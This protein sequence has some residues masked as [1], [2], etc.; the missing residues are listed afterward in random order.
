MMNTETFQYLVTLQPT[1]NFYFGGERHFSFSGEKNYLVKS[2]PFP[3][4]TTL[5]GMLRYEL[6]R[7]AGLL[8]GKAGLTPDQTKQQQDLIGAKGF[9]TDNS[10][11]Y[12]I[13]RQLSPVFLY[14]RNSGKGFLHRGN[15][16]QEG[17]A[18]YPI[19][20]STGKDALVLLKGYDAKKLLDEQLIHPPGNESLDM[21]DIYRFPVQTG[22]QKNNKQQE[23][24]ALY[25]QTYCRF[26]AKDVKG[27]PVQ[28]CF[29]F[30][31]TTSEPIALAQNS[32]VSMGGDQSAFVL[33]YEAGS[34][35]LFTEPASPEGADLLQV[36]LLS[37]AFCEKDIGALSDAAIA[38]STGFRFIETTA[39]TKNYYQVTYRK[40]KTESEDMLR[41]IKYNLYKAGA[42]FWLSAA[43]L[44]NFREALAQPA[45]SNIG[46]NYFTIQKIPL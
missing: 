46:Y 7:T 37:D 39:R 29:A 4:Q 10:D 2:N 13:I 25:K 31:L 6:L 43:Q 15:A 41:S 40:N 32:I 42:V 12:G 19:K 23:A 22:N 28:W 36:T 33:R 16:W 18:I 35:S 3:Q 1:G 5:L 45:F 8:N 44:N 34:E 27:K 20:E 17:K 11:G 14:E 9:A 21:K 24:E 26:A 30:Y 38:F